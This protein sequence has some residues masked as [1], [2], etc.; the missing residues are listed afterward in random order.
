MLAERLTIGSAM[1]FFSWAT[2]HGFCDLRMVVLLH[3][4]DLPGH[5]D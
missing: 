4:L 1:E 5:L 3:K 2:H